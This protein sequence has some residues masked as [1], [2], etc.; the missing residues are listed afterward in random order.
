MEQIKI[1][2]SNEGLQKLIEM[3]IEYTVVSVDVIDFDYSADMI[4]NELKKNANK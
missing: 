2:I 1:I 4:W 3:G